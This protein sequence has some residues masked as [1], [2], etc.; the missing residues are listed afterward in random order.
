MNCFQV[1]I[2]TVFFTTC[3]LCAASTNDV[4]H[5]KKLST[6]SAVQPRAF[7]FNSMLKMFEE[8]EWD[9]IFVKMLKI[10][11]NYFMDKALTRVFGTSGR[12]GSFS[13]SSWLFPTPLLTKVVRQRRTATTKGLKD[14]PT[15][16][17]S[18][19]DSHLLWPDKENEFSQLE[20]IC[21][22]G[23]LLARVPVLEQLAKIF[24]ETK[25]SRNERNAFVRGAQK[26]DCKLHYPKCQTFKNYNI[27]NIQDDC[28]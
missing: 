7:F 16:Q 21:S 5:S 17:R 10:A 20:V 24:I 23:Q 26:K 15:V 14:L 18:P 11:I 2:I 28:F 13:V 19:T 22:F 25:G 27:Y 9:V 1:T 6:V 4:D 8:A 3:C 12:Q